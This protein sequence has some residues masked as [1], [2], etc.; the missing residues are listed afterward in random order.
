MAAS[1]EVLLRGSGLEE[2]IDAITAVADSV[3]DIREMEE[4]DMKLVE[5]S[6][7]L[8]KKRKFAASSRKSR[9]GKSTGVERRRR[10]VATSAQCARDWRRTTTKQSR[11]TFPSQSSRDHRRLRSCRLRRRS[12]RNRRQRIRNHRRQRSPKRRRLNAWLMTLKFRRRTVPWRTR[13]GGRSG[14]AIRFDS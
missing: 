5:E 7:S 11:P 10:R 2:S 13:P 4:E 8:I 12:R 3:S 1:F 14:L 6:L 9:A